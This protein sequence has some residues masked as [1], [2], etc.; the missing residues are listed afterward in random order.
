MKANE[1][2]YGK[3]GANFIAKTTDGAIRPIKEQVELQTKR[4]VDDA[5]IKDFMEK[6][7]FQN[8]NF[9]H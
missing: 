4:T 3:A 7:I 5:A 8:L 2:L 6:I 9:K 1:I